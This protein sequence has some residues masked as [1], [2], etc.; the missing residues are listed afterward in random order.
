MKWKTGLLIV[1]IGLIFLMSS[2]NLNGKSGGFIL[3]GPV[4]IV[5]GSNFN[6][7]LLMAVLGMTLMIVATVFSFLWKQAE[8]PNANY[9][10]KADHSSDENV[11]DKY[12]GTTLKGGGVIMIGPLPLVFGSDPRTT[13]ILIMLAMVLMLMG[14]LALR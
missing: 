10:T 1:F 7:T 3:I 2:Q 11:E 14:I 4:P 9:G 8:K 13:F 12:K 6:T 5:F